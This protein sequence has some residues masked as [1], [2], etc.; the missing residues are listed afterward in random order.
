V[1]KAF[2]ECSGGSGGLPL[3][4]VDGKFAMAGRYPDRADLA[5]LAGISS[6]DPAQPAAPCCS[7]SRCC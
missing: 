7:G 1:V 5:R 4:L 6:A 2:L 3:I